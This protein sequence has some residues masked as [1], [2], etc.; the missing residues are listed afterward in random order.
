MIRIRERSDAARRAE[1]A[2][3]TRI[4][5]LGRLL[6]RRGSVIAWWAEERLHAMRDDRPVR[7]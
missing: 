1:M 7:R 2:A 3:L 4:A 5:T 6:R